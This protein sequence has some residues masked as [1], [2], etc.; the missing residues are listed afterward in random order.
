[1]RQ[2]RV[3]GILERVGKNISGGIMNILQAALSRVDIV[4]SQLQAKAWGRFLHAYED[5]RVEQS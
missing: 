2:Q 1:M 4:K 5:K 3:K